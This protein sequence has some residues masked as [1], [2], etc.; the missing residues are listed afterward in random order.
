MEDTSILGSGLSFVG[1]YRDDNQDAIRISQPV[2]DDASYRYGYLFGI[3]DGMG[4]YSH[5]G[6]A[7]VTALTT[8]FEMFYSG[9][10]GKSHQNLRQA[11]QHANMAV[12]Q[13]SQRLGSVRMGTTLSVVNI[14]GNQL[15]IAHIGDSR[16][17]LVRGRQVTCLTN[18][19]TQVGELVRMKL[20]TPDKLRTHEQRSVLNRCV[21]MQLF[22]QVDISQA[23]LQSDD[24][25]ILCTDGVWAVIEDQEFLEIVH[26]VRDPALISE[27]LIAEAMER[28][29]DDNASAITIH[30]RQIPQG[31]TAANE[32]PGLSQTLKKWFFPG[33]A[34]LV[35]TSLG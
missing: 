24:Y 6:V 2:L 23:V 14:L 35:K 29:S 5:G 13:A 30:I 21:G 10:A 28:D 27:R 11:M 16:V 33:A 12:F 18:D 1:K 20:L 31:E 8:F 4:G 26:A 22:V 32:R 25:I 15:H 3:A 17:Y 9:T 34:K 19:H 7:S